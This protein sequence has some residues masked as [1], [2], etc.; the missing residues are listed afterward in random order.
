MG[1]IVAISSAVARGHVG[2]S[3]AAFALRRLG[4]PVWALP[5]VTMPWHPGHGPSHRTVTPAGDL[6]AMLDEIAASRFAGEIGAVLSGYVAAPEQAGAIA[7][8]VD[9]VRARGGEIVY[10]CDPILGDDGRLYVAEDIAAAIR[11]H[12]VPRADI[13]TP[14]L[15]ELGW[16]ASRTLADNDAVRAAAAALGAA[17]TLVTSA[18]PLTR[19]GCASLLAGRDGAFLAE[20][21]RLDGAPHGTGDLMAALYLARRL[22]G[23]R[24]EDAL[25]RASA[26]LFALIA[27]TVRAGSDEFALAEQ[28]D[29]LLRAEVP[30]RMHRLGA[31]RPA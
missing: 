27:R 23:A 5:T 3:A 8:F 29:A 15:F 21:R 30:V 9:A 28:Q 22:G 1:A 11:D 20:T 25:A 24:P 7:R 2:N 16:L 26:S 19:E 4:F 6:A 31:M 13:L 18:F 12:L 17:E 14:N 10:C